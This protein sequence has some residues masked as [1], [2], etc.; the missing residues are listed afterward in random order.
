MQFEMAAPCLFGLEKIVKYE[1]QRAGGTEIRVQDG[2][3]FFKGDAKV[4][5]MANL[6]LQTAERV[7]LVLGEF[8]AKTFEDLFQGVKAIPWEQYLDKH[9]AFPVKGWSVSSQLTSIPACQ[10]IVKKAVVERLKAAYDLPWLEETQ[11]PVQILF[12]LLRNR[13]CIMIDTTGAPLH[14]RG[15]RANANEA[16]IK[17]T[18]ASGLA[19]LAGVRANSKV[20]DPLCGSGT[21][22]IEAG[23]RAKG[24][25]V[26]FKRSF[27]CENHPYLPKAAMAEAKKAAA[28][29]GRPSAFQGFGWDIDKKSVALAKEN[30]KKAG[31]ADCI[32]IAYGDVAKFE[33]PTQGIVLCNPPYGDRLLDQEACAKLYEVMGRRFFPK[34][35]VTYG[36]IT[37]AETF[38]SSFGRKAA[39]KRKIYNGMKKCDFYLFESGGGKGGR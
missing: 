9:T 28:T 15:Y 24:L 38:E 26:G 36:V 22:L 31:L 18:L 17:E 32:E 12:S 2:R 20:Y 33:A 7:Q 8:D 13:A 14:K 34:E 19:D 3:V 30:V 5:A 25:A 23:L 6:T 35:G 21:L 29:W 1:V 16:P 4:L 37:A 39:K 11:E 27:A 10:S